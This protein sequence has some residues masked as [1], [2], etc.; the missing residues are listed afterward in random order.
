MGWNVLSIF[1]GNGYGNL[2]QF[3]KFKSVWQCAIYGLPVK[4]MLMSRGIS[5][6]CIC[7]IC[8]RESETTIHVLR[9]CSFAKDFWLHSGYTSCDSV[10][11]NSDI[12][13]WLKRNLCS[14]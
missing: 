1:L 12:C 8:G 13:S 3:Q 2:I 11:F 14:K 10:F 6:D 9:D 4:D 5:E 7:E